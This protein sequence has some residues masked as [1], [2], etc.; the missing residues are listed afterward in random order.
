MI[1]MLH[2]LYVEE[3]MLSSNL[4]LLLEF[5]RRD[6]VITN[7]Q[8]TVS[9]FPAYQCMVGFEVSH[10][11]LSSLRASMGQS[12]H[13]LFVEGGGGWSGDQWGGPPTHHFPI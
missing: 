3:E 6:Q 12:H 13:L 8:V 5:H 2:W 9:S 11:S 10:C 1:E 7:R 4:L